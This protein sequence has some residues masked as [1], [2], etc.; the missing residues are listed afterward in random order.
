MKGI[1]GS[2]RVKLIASLFLVVLVILTSIY[3]VINRTTESEFKDYV[4]K[5][6][7][8]QMKGIEGSLVEYYEKNQTW[9]GVGTLFQDQVSDQLRGNRRGVGTGAGGSQNVA[10]V[11]LDRNVIAAY[12]QAIVGEKVPPGAV[13]Q[14]IHLEVGGERIGT[15]LAGPLLHGE[16]DQAEQQFLDT[17]NRTILISGAIGL[18]IALILGGVLFRQLTQPLNKLTTATEK[19]SSGDLDHRVTIESYDELGELGE[20]F[21]QMTENLQASENIRRRMISDIAHEL[22]TPLTVLSGEIEAIREGIYEP[23]DAKL[24]E[25]QEDLNLLNRL[26]E[27]LR[28]LSLA[29]A[30][31]L[32]LNKGRTNLSELVRRAV[33]RLQEIAGEEGIEL[34]G[35]TPENFPALNLDADRILQVLNNLIKNAIRHTNEGGEVVIEA[36]D[37]SADVLVSVVDDGEGI[38]PEKAKHVFDRFYR[39]DSARSGDGGSGLGLSIAKELVEAHGGEIWIDS[40]VGAGTTARFTLPKSE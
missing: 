22:R 31:E 35:E 21:N 23:T 33:D 19:I 36:R 13:G 7:T 1:F 25:I 12:D 20:S 30:G 2:F 9:D 10:L 16:L 5:G 29:E 11:G 4:I 3:F 14:G 37:R 32:Q 28:E 39:A 40:E 8:N 27:D 34:R 18:G 15:V 24:E 38:P 17:V 6:N 26:I